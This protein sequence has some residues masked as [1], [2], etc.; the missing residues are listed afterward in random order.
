[1]DPIYLIPNS[2]KKNFDTNYFMTVI[3]ICD[4][5]II[6][7]ICKYYKDNIY[8]NLISKSFIPKI[9]DLSWHSNISLKKIEI[10]YDEANFKSCLCILL[11]F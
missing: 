7:I 4:Y 11:Q 5:V 10:R 6:Y 8:T 3:N 9:I 2:A 1:M